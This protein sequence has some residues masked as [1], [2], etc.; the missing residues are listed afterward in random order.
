[1]GASPCVTLCAL[2]MGDVTSSAGLRSCSAPVR[3]A[4]PTASA[5]KLSCSNFGSCD[6]VTPGAMKSSSRTSRFQVSLSMSDVGARPPADSTMEKS[7]AFSPPDA[8]L[9]PPC[10]WLSCSKSCFVHTLME[11]GTF[12]V[13][14]DALGLGLP[15]AIGAE[16]AEAMPAMLT[17]AAAAPALLS[18]CG[19]PPLAA[20]GPFVRYCC[21]VRGDGGGAGSAST[22]CTAS[23]RRR[24]ASVLVC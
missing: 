9:P 18:G 8:P 7:C 11:K 3:T 1:M 22:A 2:G 17:P 16:L 13:P 14:D 23:A 24:S 12:S 6:G 4:P 21:V 10:A 5:W 19:A 15:K 20:S